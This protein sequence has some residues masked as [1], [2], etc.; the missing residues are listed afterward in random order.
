MTP[1]PGLA[2]AEHLF[3]RLRNLYGHLVAER[4]LGVEVDLDAVS[5]RRREW[6]R[7]KEELGDSLPAADSRLLDLMSATLRE[8]EDW[9]SLGDEDPVVDLRRDTLSAYT[10]VAAGVPLGDG[11][12]DRLSI[13]ELLETASDEPARRDAFM[14]MAPIWEAVDGDG[15]DDS[16]YRRLLPAS[17]SSWGVSGFPLHLG[18]AHLGVDPA[19]IEADLVDILRAFRRLMPGRTIEPWDFRFLCG[20][21]EREVEVPLASL[22]EHNDRHLASL[23]APGRPEVRYHIM[24]EPE[25]APLALAFTLAESIGWEE[26]GEWHPA[27]PVVFAWYATGGLGHLSE[28]VHESGHALHYLATRARPAEF[29]WPLEALPFVEAVGEL[30]GWNVSEPTFVAA[31]FGASISDEEA[32]LYRYGPLMLDVLWTLFEVELHRHPDRR[33]NDVWAQLS[34]DHLGVA[35]HPEWSW[36][37]V[38]GQLIESPG[39]LSN[40]ALGG[41]VVAALRERMATKRP[42]WWLGDPSW[43]AYASEHLLRFGA[44]GSSS[45]IIEGF[46]GEPLTT[47]AILSDLEG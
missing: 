25:R 39:Y 34:E 32:R 17:A 42:Q 2:D 37:A 5:D 23:G 30:L 10:G 24:P 40:Y 36:W 38:R 28:L 22:Q 14:A 26:A 16:P 12:L 41:I 35:G 45:D 18:A 3:S 19:R 15:G 31:T 13:F 33:P 44:T 1:R 21:A 20:A 7:I 9:L 46:L 29:D 6:R 43:Y 4:T 11:T 27:A 8:L 47:R